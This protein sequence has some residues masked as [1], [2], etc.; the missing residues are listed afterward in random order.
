VIALE[1]ILQELAGVP[2]PW[3]QDLR[4]IFWFVRHRLLVDTVPLLRNGLRDCHKEAV[5]RE[6]MSL[7]QL[8]VPLEHRLQPL[9]VCFRIQPNGVLQIIVLEGEIWVSQILFGFYRPCAVQRAEAADRTGCCEHR[10][11]GSGAL[12]V[13]DTRNGYIRWLA[14]LHQQEIHVAS[15]LGIAKAAVDDTEQALFRTTYMLH[16]LFGVFNKI[17]LLGSPDTFQ[18]QAF[19]AAAK[20][21]RT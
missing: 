16:I 15:I 18:N 8:G 13:I 4:G 14:I 2:A 19:V 10:P 20:D 1:A 6:T 11:I 5:I 7:E 3:G 21:P 17:V 9:P 12:E